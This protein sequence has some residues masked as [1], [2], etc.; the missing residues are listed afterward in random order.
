MRADLVKVS[1][2][3]CGGF[4]TN[5]NSKTVPYPNSGFGKTYPGTESKYKPVI[6]D[7]NNTAFHAG[8]SNFYTNVHEGP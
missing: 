5:F 1:H 2:T 3:H 8:R 7:L 4:T 6:P